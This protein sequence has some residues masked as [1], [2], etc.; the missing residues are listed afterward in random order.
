MNPVQRREAGPRHRVV[1]EGL[2][3]FWSAVEKRTLSLYT[4]VLKEEEQKQKHS[5]WKMSL[6]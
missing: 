5:Q 3:E 4:F 6:R 2:N 1:S